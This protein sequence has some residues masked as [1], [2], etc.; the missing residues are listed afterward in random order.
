MENNK[1][2]RREFLLTGTKA[3]VFGSIALSSFDVVRLIASSKDS[4]T[5]ESTG[6]DKVIKISDYPS[7]ASTGGYEEIAKNI[8]IIRTSSTKFI[9]VYTVCTHKKCDVDFDGNSFE[10][11]CHGS[12]FTKTGKVTGGPATKNLKTFK[13]VFDAENNTLTIKM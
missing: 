5:S 13:T 9:A 6:N 1:I 8:L 11:P 12:T 4:E 2:N 7:L 3:A 10:C